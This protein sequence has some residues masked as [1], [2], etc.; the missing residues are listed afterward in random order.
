MSKSL[1][2]GISLQEILKQY[3]ADIVRLW[4]ASADYKQDMRISKEMFKHLS[5]NYLKIRNTARY[6]LGN[7]N[8]FEVSQLLPY[9]ELEELDQWALMKLN[10]LVT[11]V[12]GA[13]DAYEFHTVLHA[14]HNFCVVDMSNF[15]LDVIKDR[16]Y[17]DEGKLR[18]SAQTAMFHIL[19]AIVRMV[20][21]ILCFTSDEIWKAMPH[22]EGDDLRNIALNGMPA[23]NAAYAF[24]AKKQEKWTRLLVLRDEVNKALEAARNQKIIGK[25][26]EAAV[27]VELNGVDCAYFR[28]NF[29]EEALAD[30]CIVSEMHVS[31]G[32]GAPKTVEN[33]YGLKVTVA[34]AEGKKCERCWKFV[35][36]VGSDSRHPALCARCASVVG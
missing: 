23:P 35:G 27:T 12:I 34:H 1:G 24:D 36:S 6:I 3:G 32:E 13:Y 8:G 2:N 16:L 18:L 11:K 9:G 22:Q 31:E 5:Q 30:L 33:R 14:I 17:C 4:V 15:Y 25:P 19:D 20:S 21:P 29:T 7:L 26:L 10:E 28:E